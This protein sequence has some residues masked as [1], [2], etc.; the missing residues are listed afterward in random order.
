MVRNAY[1]EKYDIFYRV[2]LLSNTPSNKLISRFEMPNMFAD[3][4]QSLTAV[5]TS[6]IILFAT[7]GVSIYSS[8][9]LS[10]IDKSDSLVLLLIS[11][12]WWSIK[13]GIY[14]QLLHSLLLLFRCPFT[15]GQVHILQCPAEFVIFCQKEN[16]IIKL[17]GI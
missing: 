9:E 8:Q 16:V 17:Q 6:L 1:F 7:S 3:A 4:R 13:V 2:I 5:T 11:K 12:L 15:L 10:K 14:I